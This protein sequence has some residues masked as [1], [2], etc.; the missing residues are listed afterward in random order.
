MAATLAAICRLILVGRRKDV[1]VGHQ[2][3]Q[4]S[5]DVD[6]LDVLLE[7]D[8]VTRFELARV[9]DGVLLEGLDDFRLEHFTEGVDRGFVI[10]KAALAGLLLP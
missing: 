10:E 1:A 4:L 8:L 2:H 3:H 9:E 7:R 5:F 6:G